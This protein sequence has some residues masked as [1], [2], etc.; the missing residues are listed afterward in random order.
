MAECAA[1]LVDEVLPHEPMRQW[2]LSFPYPLRFLF[3][4]RPAVM[5]RVLG[6]VYRTLATHLIRKAGFK[7]GTADTGAVTLI[8][9]FGSA[10]N[11]HTICGAAHITF[12]LSALP[13][14][15]ISVTAPVCAVLRVNPAFLIRWVARVR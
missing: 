8:Q 12:K 1:L 3:A 10:L 7:P 6:I 2:V 11:A 5:S 9:C 13:K 14:H 4:R 15:W